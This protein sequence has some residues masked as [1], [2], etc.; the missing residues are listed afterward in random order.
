MIHNG[1]IVIHCL[2][3]HHQTA[4]ITSLF[5]VLTQTV[6]CC[7]RAIA[8]INKNVIDLIFFQSC[9]N[10]VIILFR[11]LPH[12]ISA[13]AKS[14]GRCITQTQKLH[15]IHICTVIQMVM[16]QSINSMQ[17]C[18]QLVAFFQKLLAFPDH[19]GGRTVDHC[20]RSSG[21]YIQSISHV[22]VS[23]AFLL[24]QNQFSNC[25]F[26]VFC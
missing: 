1:N 22:S 18:I 15:F 9:K 7:Y 8:A 14:H 23:Q 25:L 20:R 13:G 26:Y 11:I 5:Q 12:C 17:A 21:L 10:P 19:T 16:K 2:R 4:W 24:F 6:A 3:D